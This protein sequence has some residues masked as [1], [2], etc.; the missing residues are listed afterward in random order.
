MLTLN[1]EMPTLNDEKLKTY[2]VKLGLNEEK[3]KC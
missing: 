2:D 1:D 3:S